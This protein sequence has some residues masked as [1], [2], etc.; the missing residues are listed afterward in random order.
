MPSTITM[1]FIGLIIGISIG[2]VLKE[3][4]GLTFKI[5]REDNKNEKC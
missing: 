4:L 1:F 3:R 2:W 5:E